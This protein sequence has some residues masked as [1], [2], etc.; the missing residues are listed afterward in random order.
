MNN[1]IFIQPIDSKEIANIISSLNINKASGPFSVPNK[2]L[3]PLKQDTSKQLADLFNLS[4]SSGSIPFILKTAKV[5]SVFKKGSKLDYC[6]Y[7]PSLFHQMLK[8]HLKNLCIKATC[9]L[10]NLSFSSGSFPFILK[11]AK[12]VP[13]FKKGSKLDYCNYRPISLLSNVQKTLEKLMYKRVYNFLAENN[14]VYDLQFSFRKK[15]STSHALISLTENIRQ[16]L[17]E[18]YIGCGIFVDL[19]KAFDT[20]DHEILLSKLDYCGIRGISNN[21]FKSYLSNRKQFASINGYDSG[22]AKINCGVTQGYA[23]GPLLFLFT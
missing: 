22:L 10:F 14:V 19:Q 7:R 23:L 16:A 17:D 8:K 9:R 4:F 1:S 21:W 20:V 5:V 6:N 18:E 2:I 11:T 13:V 3:I 15:C 12:V